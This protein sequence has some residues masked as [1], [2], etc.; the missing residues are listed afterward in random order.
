MN[1]LRERRIILLIIFGVIIA[2]FVGRL[3]YLQILSQD[4]SASA[5]KNVIKRQVLEPTRGVLYDRQMRVFVTNAPIFELNIVPRDLSMP[6]TQVF[7]RYLRLDR[8]QLKRRVKLATDYSRHKASVLER[9]ID[10]QSYTALQEHLWATK[11]INTLVRTTRNYLY[12]VGSNFLGYIS[13]VNKKD[14]E[15]SGGYYSQGD[16]I[17]TSGL[18]R[19]YESYLRGRKGV[20]NIMVDVHG[21]DVGAFAGGRYDTIPEKG[22]D[23]QLTVDAELQLFAEALMRGKSG[24]IVALEPATGEVLA[25][26][27]SPSYNP[28]LLTGGETSNHWRTLSLDTLKPL[29]NR[30]LMAMYPPGSVFKVLNAL[31]ALEEGTLSEYTL[32]GCAGGFARNGGRPKCHAHPTP[33]NLAGAIQH[34]CNAYFAGTYLD[35]LHNTQR[36]ASFNQAYGIWREHMDRFGVGHRIGID[37]PNE[38][39]GNLPTENYYNKIYGAGRWF[40]MTI[41]SNSIGQGELLMTPLQMANV[42]AMLANRGYYLQPHFFKQFVGKT[43]RKFSHIDTL[44][45]GIDPKHFTVVIDAMEKVVNEGTGIL[46]KIPDVAVCG[47]TGTAENPHGEDHSV[48]FA[49]APKENP[50]I[51]IAVIIENAGWGGVWAAPMASLV[52]EKYLKGEISD[53]YK[54]QRV[55]DAEFISKTYPTVAK[56]K[57]PLLERPELLRLLELEGR[58]NVRKIDPAMLPKAQWATATATPANEALSKQTGLQL[59]ALQTPALNLAPAAGMAVP[60]LQPIAAPPVTADPPKSNKP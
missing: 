48:F 57:N 35:M 39:A 6:D 38:K 24:S 49:F 27:S 21:R 54:L 19:Q 46:A 41:I 16:L 20:R 56:N 59:E 32:Y 4:Y 58:K 23:I 5:D 28:N 34:S 2:V 18:E 9:Q 47:K 11:G 55:L 26:V 13:E 43:N 8:D 36:F 42:A 44:R 51:A 25:F 53:A 45:T 1:E 33:L 3:F 17:G 10:A 14:I 50:K 7:T 60:A 12:P 40:G 30:P 52:M 15:K 22:A 37:V 29:F 31:C